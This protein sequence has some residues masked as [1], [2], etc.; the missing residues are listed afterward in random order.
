MIY[1]NV[2]VYLCVQNSGSLCSF[3]FIVISYQL[4]KS[5]PLSNCIEEEIRT[6]IRFLHSERMKPVKICRIKLQYENCL[7][8]SKIY[9]WIDCF[10]N[11]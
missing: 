6:V 11:E 8:R 2:E 7:N 3:F 9:E 5:F 1:Y 10:K 4:K